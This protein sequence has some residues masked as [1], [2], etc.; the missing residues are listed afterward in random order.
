[1]ILVCRDGITV[2]SWISG[3]TMSKSFMGCKIAPS[4]LSVYSRILL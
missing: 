4:L 3:R 1:M 2:S